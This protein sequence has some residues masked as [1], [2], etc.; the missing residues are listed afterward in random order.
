EVIFFDG[1]LQE[2]VSNLPTFDTDFFQIPPGNTPGSIYLVVNE[3]GRG[4]DASKRAS[5]FLKG[6]I[7]AGIDIGLKQATTKKDAAEAPAK[8][9]APAS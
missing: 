5:E 8:G 7:G 4:Q 9:G 3:E 2:K 1:T 6:L